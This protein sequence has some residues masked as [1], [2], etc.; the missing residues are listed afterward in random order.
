MRG[1]SALMFLVLLGN[2]PASLRAQASAQDEQQAV[3]EVASPWY[4][5]GE[6]GSARIHN[7]DDRAVWLALR[8]GRG[9][10]STG[11]FRLGAG[12]TYSSSGENFLTA[13]VDLEVLPI[14]AGMVTPVL[15]GGIGLL[16]EPEW[17]GVVLDGWGGLAVRVTRMVALRA[18]YQYSVHGGEAG[19]KGFLVGLEVSARPSS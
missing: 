17:G 18:V 10:E 9:L 3:T 15:G 7:W 11:S 19:P 2:G 1:L 5:R 14:P 13:E 8:V 6:A 12:L 4:F 16:T